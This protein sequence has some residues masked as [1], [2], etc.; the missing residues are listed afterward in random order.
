MIG[1]IPN[2]VVE[3]RNIKITSE[4]Y[5]T[6]IT[7]YAKELHERCLFPMH[8]VCGWREI[9][10]TKNGYRSVPTTT[11]PE[12]MLKAKTLAAKA[13]IDGLVIEFDPL[14]EARSISY[15]KFKLDLFLLLTGKPPSPIP[16]YGYQIPLESILY[17]CQ[18]YDPG[19][20]MAWCNQSTS[21]TS[22][23]LDNTYLHLAF[24]AKKGIAEAITTEFQLGK[25]DEILYNLAFRLFVADLKLRR[26]VFSVE[27]SKPSQAKTALLGERAAD[28][29][30]AVEELRDLLVKRRG[31]TKGSMPKDLSGVHSEIERR[32]EVAYCFDPFWPYY[33]IN[34]F[35]NMHLLPIRP[36]YIM[37]T[38]GQKVLN[39]LYFCSQYY[40]SS[41]AVK[42]KMHWKAPIRNLT[43]WSVDNLTD[44]I[45][46]YEA[47]QQHAPTS[48]SAS[49]ITS[50][51]MRLGKLQ[52]AP[53]ARQ[54]REQKR[55]KTKKAGLMAA[56]LLGVA[57]EQTGN[58]VI[59]EEMM[60]ED[61][62]N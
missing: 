25:K 16:R 59:N 2:G 57:I 45:R 52:L 34:Y 24:E 56:K 37:I 50:L 10:W 33:E 61:Q 28:K 5:D 11:D 58:K 60:E 26:V 18:H 35:I 14:T 15:Q 42:E 40:N 43:T 8:G 19:N 36:G 1:G 55:Q 17:N 54:T 13:V 31:T 22:V 32:I 53:T 41:A 29:Q 39:E 46:K 27:N 9:A 12:T 4:E 49:S 51:A 30:Q 38:N 48:S 62:T 44:L 3:G 21:K 7:D 6:I 23:F 47:P 20:F